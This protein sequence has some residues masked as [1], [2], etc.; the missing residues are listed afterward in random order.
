MIYEEQIEITKEEIDRYNFLLATNLEDMTEKQKDVYNAKAYDSFG[1]YE[2]DFDDGSYLTIDLASGS[3]NY[4][5][6][7]VWHSTKEINSR[8]I[9]FDCSYELGI[10]DEFEVDGNIYKVHWIITDEK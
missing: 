5:D 3:E 9:T 8:D 6:D 2:I 7:I 10:D 1:L 4:Y